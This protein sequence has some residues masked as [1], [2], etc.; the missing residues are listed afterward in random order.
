LHKAYPS[1]K[2]SL[3]AKTGKPQDWPT[4]EAIPGL[5]DR[6]S[7]ETV[8][9][10]CIHCHMVRENM[11]RTKWEEKRLTREDIYVYPTPQRIGLTIDIDD[12]LK[13]K[14]VV[15]GSV[16]AKAGL[17]AG[18]QFRSLNGQPL[19]SMADIQWVLHNAPVE[20]SLA[21][22]V[23]RDGKPVEKTM[24]LSGDWKESDIAWRASSWTGLRQA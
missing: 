21:V 15:D 16:A 14:S 19:I 5:K 24:Q 8:R 9:K 4:P 11:M 17:A 6:A 12:G 22:V 13:V 1:N 18:D 20:S 2:A 23:E 10:T 7:G 3:A